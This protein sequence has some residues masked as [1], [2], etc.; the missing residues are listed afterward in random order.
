[1]IMQVILHQSEEQSGIIAEVIEYEIDHCEGTNEYFERPEL[2]YDI[3][4]LLNIGEINSAE[5]LLFEAVSTDENKTYLPLAME[6]YA[7]LSE[8]S[9]DFLIKHGY[10]HEEIGQGLKEILKIYNIEMRN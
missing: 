1:M 10:S 2:Y 6:F 7:N 8:M 3:M 4:T 9:N 5:N